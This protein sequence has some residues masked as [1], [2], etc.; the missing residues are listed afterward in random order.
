MFCLG[1]LLIIWAG[2]KFVDSSVFFAKVFGI[3]EMI[4]G[5]TIVSLGTTLPEILVSLTASF[6]GAPDIA[7]GNALG[8]IICNTAFVAGITQL[9]RPAGSVDRHAM[10]WR[11]FYF[12][13]VAI[14][15]FAFGAGMGEFNRICGTLLIGMFVL[16]AVFN[17]QSATVPRE[18]TPYTDVS[19][20]LKHRH[21]F[22]LVLSAAL[23]YLGANL[24]V[25]NGIIIARHFGI[26]ERV[27]GVTF[28]ALGTSLPELVTAISAMVKGHALLSVGNIIGANCLNLLLVI[29]IPSLIHG[30]TPSSTAV[31]IDLPVAVLAMAVLVFPMLWGRRGS[32][33]QGLA[34]TAGYVVYCVLQF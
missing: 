33:I 6:R 16:Y 11:S 25:D 30:I 14:V 5:A 12:F 27:I 32:R 8:S 2:D 28:I 15:V 7:V 19:S 24:L 29:G 34:L 9:I 10:A 3:P 1:L 21:L 20:S 18:E 23:L 22:F 31:F 26:P 17:V 13:G 4:I